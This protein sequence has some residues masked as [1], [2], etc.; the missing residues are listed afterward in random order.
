MP[1]T[2]CVVGEGM[3]AIAGGE[4]ATS[5]RLARTRQVFECVRSCMRDQQASGFNAITGVSGSGPAYR[6]LEAM[7]DAGGAPFGLPRNIA[8]A[9]L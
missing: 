8:L 7:A 1:N 5:P 9:S 4:R 3:T 2:P 6:Y